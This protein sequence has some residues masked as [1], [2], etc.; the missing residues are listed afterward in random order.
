MAN[1]PPGTHWRD[2]ARNARFFMV[3]ARAV[4]PLFFFLLHIRFWTFFTALGAVLF[5]S[6]LERYG[7]SVVVFLRWLR[8]FLAGPRKN[9][10]PWW[11]Y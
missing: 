1:I 10:M 5:F 11:K 4:F 3:D 2:S 7:F 9:S 8:T 6:L